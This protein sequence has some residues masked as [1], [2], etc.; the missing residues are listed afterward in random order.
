MMLYGKEKKVCSKCYKTNGPLPRSSFISNKMWFAH[1]EDRTC[2][3]CMTRR[4][5]GIW[6]CIQCKRELATAFISKCKEKRSIPKGR[7]SVAN[8]G[9][10]RCKECKQKENDEQQFLTRNSGRSQWAFKTRINLLID[11]EHVCFPNCSSSLSFIWL[12]HS[13]KTIKSCSLQKV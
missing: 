11:E 3:N 6:K 4:P 12:Q 13:K 10:A 9:T 5:N 2:K 1:D 8:D 7:S